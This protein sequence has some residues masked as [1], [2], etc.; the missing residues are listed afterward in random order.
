[1]NR[2]LQGP[3]AERLLQVLQQVVDVLDAH[4]ET[5]QVGGYLQGGARR[6]LVVTLAAAV[7][8]TACGGKKNA[9]ATDATQPDR[10]LF[11]RGTDALKRERCQA[12]RRR[13]IFR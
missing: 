2:R 10:F 9:V 6:T 5:D 8:L 1:M 7:M 13:R 3:L 11:D 12:W 4:G